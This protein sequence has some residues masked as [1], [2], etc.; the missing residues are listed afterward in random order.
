MLL[1]TYQLN[2]DKHC[3]FLIYN[4]SIIC[5]LFNVSISHL[6]N[7]Y[8]TKDYNVQEIVKDI[9]LYENLVAIS[10]EFASK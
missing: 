7:I 10:W 6:A 1:L 9:E 4:T 5:L 3:I 2:V 8:L